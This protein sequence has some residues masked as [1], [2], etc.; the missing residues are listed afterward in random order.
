[1][2]ILK[3]L[4]Q[5]MIDHVES[6]HTLPKE[7]GGAIASVKSEG[8]TNQVIAKKMSMVDRM[9][10]NISVSNGNDS[11]SSGKYFMPARSNPA[12]S[13][14]LKGVHA[15][16]I[17]SKAIPTSRLAFMP[18]KKPTVRSPAKGLVGQFHSRSRFAVPPARKEAAEKYY[19][20]GLTT[21]S[22]I[23]EDAV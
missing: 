20:G 3:T 19:H 12:A 23:S 8:S 14:K 6:A 16:L 2:T 5:K 18:V 15:K 9:Q 22:L 17:K 1:M 7:V 21:H 13:I 11:Y 10:S 4:T